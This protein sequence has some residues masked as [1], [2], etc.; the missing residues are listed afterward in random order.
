MTKGMRVLVLAATVMLGGCW[1]SQHGAL[2]PANTPTVMPFRDGNLIATGGDKPETFTIT[3][4]RD[5]SYVLISSEKNDKGQD[6]G[7]YLRFFAVT[8]LPRD[9]YAYE[10]VG[11]DNCANQFICDA[12]AQ[13]DARYYGLIETTIDGA[14]DIRPDCKTDDRF[15]DKTKVKI[16]DDECI[17]P[18]RA[19]LE[20][21]LRA[22]AASGRKPDRLFR[23]H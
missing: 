15:I 21:S 16:D 9:F 5:A 13:A 6:E 7:Y 23:Y 18:D 19:S 17:F 4:R 10:A 20:A 12:V 1:E 22:L 8:G 14:N 11:I 2:Y 3:G